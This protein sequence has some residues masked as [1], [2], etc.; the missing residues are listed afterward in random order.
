MEATFRQCSLRIIRKKTFALGL[1]AS[2]L[3]ERSDAASA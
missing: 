1:Y 2:Y 3:L